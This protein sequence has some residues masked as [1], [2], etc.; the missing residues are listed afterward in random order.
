MNIIG[1]NKTLAIERMG[2]VRKN[3]H[4]T[5]MK[6]VR[7]NNSADITVEFQ[8]EHKHQVNIT[9]CNFTRGVFNPYDKVI[10]GVGCTG[11]GEYRMFIDGT[12]IHTDEY[13]SWYNM[14]CRC[15][16]D[17]RATA[18]HDCEVCNEWL[19]FQN[20]AE[21][22]SDNFYDIGEGR[23]HIDKDILVKGNRV[24]SPD[25]CIFVPQRINM[26]F[27]K[28]LNKWNLP[29]GISMSYSGK[30]IT[31]YNT[32]HLG[33]FDN[34]EEAINA[35]D[36]EKRKCIK[37]IVKEYGYRLPSKVSNALLNW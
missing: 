4:G 36:T 18:Y 35:H 3:K 27:V 30:Y 6:I 29:N 11:V 5:E 32:K 23:M 19:N 16:K 21:W 1:K 33:S 14:L 31:S 10:C 20:Y 26:L 17:K 13:V 37:Q 22:Y 34:L 15:Y 7:Y 12:H 24:Y 28:K 2:E 8:D 9:Y 25:N